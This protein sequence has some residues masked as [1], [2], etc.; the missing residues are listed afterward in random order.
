MSNSST[1]QNFGALVLASMSSLSALYTA[2][3]KV[4][5]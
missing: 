1:A 5:K 4:W 3:R 2:A